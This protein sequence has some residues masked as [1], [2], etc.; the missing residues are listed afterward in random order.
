ML[1]LLALF[2]LFNVALSFNVPEGWE[3]HSRPQS[4]E[5]LRVSFAVKHKDDAIIK[6]L[7][8]EIALPS[9]SHYRMSYWL[10]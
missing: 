7:F 5:Y 4:N 3:K 8:D 2:V 10:N 6:N 1:R 9:G